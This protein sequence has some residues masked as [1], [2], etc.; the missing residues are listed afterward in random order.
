ME[1]LTTGLLWG[2][3]ASREKEQEMATH[4]VPGANPANKDQLA[5]GCWAEHQDGSLIFVLSVEGGRVVYQMYDLLRGQIVEYKDAMPET[6][7]KKTF[8]FDGSSKS[9]KWTWHDKTPFDWNRVIKAGARDG[10]HY[11]SAVDQLSAAQRVAES[12]KLR[13]VTRNPDDFDDR[14]NQVVKDIKETIGKALDQLLR[15]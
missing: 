7:F 1:M 3:A 10:L 6:D 11:A 15:R 2:F 4:D 8:S 9:L 12:L 13:G 14:V 5:M